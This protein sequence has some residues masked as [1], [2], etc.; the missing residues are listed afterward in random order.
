LADLHQNVL[1]QTGAATVMTLRT[2][3]SVPSSKPGFYVPRLRWFTIVDPDQTIAARAHAFAAEA[4][5]VR[6]LKVSI[7]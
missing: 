6:R 7:S 2:S 4:L 3:I 5:S 1:E